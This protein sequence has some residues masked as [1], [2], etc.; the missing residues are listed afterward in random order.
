MRPHFDVLMEADHP[1]GGQWN[2][3]G[4]NRQALKKS[5]LEDITAPLTFAHDTKTVLD[6]L[7]R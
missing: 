2:F 4:D 6:R 3:D 7:A 5:D 1:L